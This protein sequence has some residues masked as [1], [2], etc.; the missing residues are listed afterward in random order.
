MEED[1]SIVLA[2]VAERAERYDEMADF[3]KERVENGTP[4]SSEERDMFSAAFK[5]ALSGR[6]NAVRVA[7]NVE[8]QEAAEGRAEKAALA[9]GYRTKVEAELQGICEKAIALLKSSLLPTAPMG[10]PKTFYLKM[11]GDYHRY[12]AEFATGDARTRAADEARQAY[13]DGT[14]EATSLPNIHPVRLGLALNFSVFQHEVLGDTQSAIQTAEKALNG[15]A[16]ELANVTEENRG[17]AYL[18][19]QLLQDNL[20]LWMPAS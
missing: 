19:M 10:E 1:K 7:V 2:R 8:S 6:R 5:G 20:S 12:A 14:E 11:K 4:L 9:A 13:T 18:T 15:A 17:D 16:S 3:M